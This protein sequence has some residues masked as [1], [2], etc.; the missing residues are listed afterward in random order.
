MQ[1]WVTTLLAI[2]GAALAAFSPIAGWAADRVNARR[3][4]MVASLIAFLGA[5]FMLCFGR[6]TGVYILA[7][8]L[9]GI[10]GAVVW[11][12]G[13]ALVV[14]TV[15]K[16]EV[17]KYLGY[18]FMSINMA[19]LIAP[20]VGGAVYA[21]R[22]YYAVFCMSFA[23]IA[24][25]VFLRITVIEKKDAEKWIVKDNRDRRQNAVVDAVH[26]SEIS[27]VEK[28]ETIRIVPQESEMNILITASRL[29]LSKTSDVKTAHQRSKP[30]SHAPIFSLMKDPRVLTALF[31]CLVQSSLFSTFDTVLPLHVHYLFGWS[32]LGSG[33]IFLSLLVPSFASPLVGCLNDKLGPKW[34]AC[35]GFMLCFVPLVLLREVTHNSLR[36]KVLL[37]TLLAIIGFGVNFIAIPLAAEVAYAI[38]AWENDKP[39][40]YDGKSA[41]AQGYALLNTGFAAGSL[42]G[43]L[44]SGYVVQQ[45]GWGTL[46][47]SLGLLCALTTIPIVVYTGGRL[48]QSP[49]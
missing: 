32:S 13:L 6:S 21:A 27:D 15:P 37:C 25:D 46:G 41:Y 1:H 35:M 28:H 29:E 19:V 40:T 22:G 24:V 18:V 31:G 42:I 14:D 20:L 8:I 9:L 5:A 48:R 3:A 38:E 43:P 16:E 4:P 30:T 33:L 23:L 7:R 45:S 26:T 10:S 44:W 34:I 12:V 11:T 17:G 36:Q 39:R 47:W 49:A 2:N